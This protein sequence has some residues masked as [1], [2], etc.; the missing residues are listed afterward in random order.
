MGFTAPTA[1]DYIDADQYVF[2]RSKIVMH[3]KYKA[4]RPEIMT[5]TYF[6][7]G[8]NHKIRN[9][10]L[11]PNKKIWYEIH[12]KKK[13]CSQSKCQLFYPRGKKCQVDSKPQV[14]KSGDSDIE[15]C[16]CAC[17]N[18]FEKTNDN[19]LNNGSTANENSSK[20]KPTIEDQYIRAP[21]VMWSY[22]QEKCIYQD[23]Y[24]FM[25]GFDD[26][27]RTDKHPTPRIDTIGT[28]MN[29]VDSDNSFDQSSYERNESNQS[30][31][32]LNGD[33]SF[34]FKLNKYYCDDFGMKFDGKD[35]VNSALSTISS[36]IFGNTL[37]NSVFYGSR[38]ISSG[39]LNTDV[40]KLDLPPIKHK[41][42]HE[43]IDSWK[44]C[45]DVNAFFLDPNVTLDMLGITA[46]KQHLIF[47]TEFGYPG[48]LVEPLII[49]RNIPIQSDI[50]S[51]NY[52]EINRQRLPQFQYDTATGR[53]KSDPY[54]ILNISRFLR[55][56]ANQT[57]E[58]YDPH[59]NREYSRRLVE[60]FHYI[61]N[62]LGDLA[63]S[64][65]MG[66]LQDVAFKLSIHLINITNAQIAH[67]LTP[68]LIFMVQRE[69]SSKLFPPLIAAF[70]VQLQKMLHSTA[71][72]LRSV[73]YMLIVSFIV[74]LFDIVIDFYNMRNLM[75][76]GSLKSYSELSIE[77]VRKTFGYG[78]FEYSPV[79][80]ML[81]CESYKLYDNYDR[82]PSVL[83][84]LKFVKDPKTY[85]YMIPIDAVQFRKKDEQLSLYT[86]NWQ[87]EYIY[88]L[89]KNSNGFSINW[90]EE[91]QLTAEEAN[92]YKDIKQDIYLQGMT[93][94]SKQTKRF[95]RRNLFAIIAIVFLIVIFVLLFVINARLL[96]GFF[97]LASTICNYIVFSY[98]DINKTS[99]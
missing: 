23:N 76:D 79:S 16:Q 64:V 43:T 6:R 37:T 63:E 75:S 34:R 68:T 12:P 83:N 25:L 49:T 61:S 52:E 11:S 80:F 21:F 33:E 28:G 77:Q 70:S 2:E 13:F 38:L 17:Y 94:Y 20:D 36:T 71:G 42:I 27:A 51:M 41:P 73:D 89:Q 5:H 74:D 56:Q 62:N 35:C 84:T 44:N 29:L 59:N 47:T 53:M 92:M 31:Y 98:F 1:N 82:L 10:W 91:P 69:L 18:L 86:F 97:V 95:Q 67:N 39:T 65:T 60:F 46:D 14:F 96:V 57:Y 85:T 45:I 4:L 32:D 90:Q 55:D 7:I 50:L 15:A 22:R 24:S 99:N 88:A 9:I 8:Y 40:Q 48:R 19:S 72:F 26:Y 81:N 3:N 58:L 78:T 30:Y 93:T 54:E 87:A 66:I